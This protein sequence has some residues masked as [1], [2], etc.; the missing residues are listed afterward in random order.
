L[1]EDEGLSEQAVSNNIFKK[2]IM[3]SNDNRLI[4][5]FYILNFVGILLNG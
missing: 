3:G 5:D 4:M 2:Q 1:A